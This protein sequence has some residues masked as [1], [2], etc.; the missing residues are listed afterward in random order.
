MS[1]NYF[2]D[3]RCDYK[4]CKWSC[5]LVKA[6]EI[7]DGS[8]KTLMAG[9]RWYQLRVWTAGNYYT[10]GAGTARS[11]EP[12]PGPPCGSA[13]SASKNISWNVP[14]NASLDAVGYYTI[15]NND[16][17]RPPMPAGGQMILG[18]NDLPF[19]S[20]H[21]GIVNFVRADGGIQVVFDDIDPAVYTAFASRNGQEVVNQ[22]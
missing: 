17:D 4:S 13:S 5:G 1:G 6:S 12:P 7:T 19:A 16:S 20:F 14:P 10:V 3:E 8:S 18:F 22:L 11:S 21:P 9:E 2:L 15:H